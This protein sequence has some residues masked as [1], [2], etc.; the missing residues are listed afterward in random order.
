[1]RRAAAVLR[2]VPLA[3]LPALVAACR[4]EA[5]W[6]AREI[7]QSAA[8]RVP[9]Q[10]NNPARVAVL[11]K[12]AGE[13]GA[14]ILFVG[15][16][17]TEGWETTGRE[18]WDRTYAPRKALDLG[19][20]GDQTQ[21]VLW[22]IAQGEMDPFHPKAVVLMIGTNNTGSGLSPEATADGVTLVVRRLVAKF[23]E[24]RILLLAVFPR[25]EKPGDPMRVA[26]ARVNAILSGIADGSRVRFLDL[27]PAFLS[28]DGTVSRE[29]M[30]DALHL[31]P[32]GYQIWAD[33][34]E[35]ALAAAL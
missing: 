23:P 10:P 20:S 26:N 17:I 12:R 8:T 21:H 35:P 3:A 6:E 2:L 9:A 18:V 33:A 13:T 30:P 1:M 11:A 32:R 22:R 5:P 25:G 29:V 16:S 15:D 34:M 31:S 19:V 27:G 24:A 28:P 14:E 7:R 4:S